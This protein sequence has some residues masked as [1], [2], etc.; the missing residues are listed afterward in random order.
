MGALE[1][2]DAEI[3]A[4]EAE[5]LMASAQADHARASIQQREAALDEARVNLSRTEIRAPLD[6]IIIR[7]DVEEGQ[8]VAASLQAPTL[9]TL[10]RDL[11][12]MRIETYVDEADIDRLRAGQARTSRSMPTPADALRGG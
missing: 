8:T 1:A 12:R 3:A 7:R 4:A 11:A 9:F 2:E 6:G 5:V 10:A